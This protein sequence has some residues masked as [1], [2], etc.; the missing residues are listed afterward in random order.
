MLDS[1]AC[2]RRRPAESN[3]RTNPD[4]KPDNN[5]YLVDKYELVVLCTFIKYHL[6]LTCWQTLS[7]HDRRI[8]RR[9]NGAWLEMRFHP[10]ERGIKFL[11]VREPVRAVRRVRPHTGDVPGMVVQIEADHHEERD[12]RCGRLHQPLHKIQVKERR[13]R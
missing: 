2:H 12:P 11:K 10:L 3:R 5:S 1:Q 9:D 4:W 13:E 7:F 6:K 8:G